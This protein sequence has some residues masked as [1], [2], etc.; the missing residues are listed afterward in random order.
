M[1]EALLLLRSFSVHG[2]ANPARR[3]IDSLIQK[4]DVFRLTKIQVAILNNDLLRLGSHRA[5]Q[6]ANDQTPYQP[7]DR[8]HRPKGCR[9]IGT[10]TKNLHDTS[11]VKSN[12]LITGVSLRGMNTPRPQM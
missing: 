9:A 3:R 7:A 1:V 4:S 11:P 10:N 6:P 5:R 12:N 8:N 2:D